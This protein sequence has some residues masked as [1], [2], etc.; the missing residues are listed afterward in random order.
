MVKA[1]NSGGEAHS[2]ADFLVVEPQEGRMLEITKTVVFNDLK[3]EEVI[4]NTNLISFINFLSLY[5]VKSLFPLTRI[6]FRI[7]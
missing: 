5:H 1:I 3:P 2:I 7:I 4:F 6:I